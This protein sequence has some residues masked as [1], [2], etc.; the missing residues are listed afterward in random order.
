MARKA[1]WGPAWGGAALI[2]CI[3]AQGAADDVRITTFRHESTYSLNGQPFTVTR[4]QDQSAV[5]SGEFARTSRAC[6]PDCLQPMSIAP[7]V[8]TAGEL[9]LIRFLET[10]MSNGDGLLIDSRDPAAFARNAIPGAVNVPA[11]TLTE[12]NRY[13][14]DILR[15]LGAVSAPDGSL[16]F[17]NAM[18]LTLYSGGPWSGTAPQAV[19]Y[20][21]LAGYPPEKLTYYR[22]GLQA[23]LHAGFTVHSTQNPG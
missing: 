8:A 17:T 15:A 18:N 4:N 13:R 3:A 9:E 20:L 23:W 21:L 22:G 10:D 6:P 5:I 12:E 16:D 7:G 2:A 11:E 19:G 1:G 14:N